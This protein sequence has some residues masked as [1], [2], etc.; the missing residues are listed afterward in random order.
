MTNSANSC[1]LCPAKAEK[2]EITFYRAKSDYCGNPRYIVHF[3]ALIKEDEKD[4]E[5]LQKKGVAVDRSRS[6]GGKVY[7]GK[8]FGGG[9]IFQS[10]SL[11]DD[12]KTIKELTGINY[13]GYNVERL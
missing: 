9:I 2:N 10:Y 6:F 12:L 1:E 5:I 8:D 3:L 4:L 7:R 13:T 11:E